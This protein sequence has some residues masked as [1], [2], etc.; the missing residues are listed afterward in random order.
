MNIS[1]PQPQKPNPYI[2]ADL[3]FS[4]HYF[5]M[6][7]FWLTYKAKAVIAFPGGFGTFDELFEILTLV[8]TGKI[9]REDMIIILYGE[10]YWRKVLDFG[11]MIDA[12]TIS[13]ADAALFSFFSDPGKA[14]AFLKKKLLKFCR[15]GGPAV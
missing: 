8:Q 6:R 11:A 5:F 9:A 1:L 14:F 12:G 3:S 7:K 13:P 2:T 10:E 15:A 4:F